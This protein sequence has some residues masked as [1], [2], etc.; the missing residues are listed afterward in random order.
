MNESWLTTHG[1]HVEVFS[2]LGIRGKRWHR[3]VAA[4]NGEIL[5][6]GEAYAR[7]IDAVT[8]A[9]RHHPRTEDEFTPCP[10]CNHARH[11]HDA[12]TGCEWCPCQN[13]WDVAA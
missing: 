1:D 7:R 13:A 6:W 10:D 9:E 11:E 12:D 3:N 2:R 5:E 4:T 8:A